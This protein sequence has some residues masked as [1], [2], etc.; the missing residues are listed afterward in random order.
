MPRTLSSPGVLHALRCF[1]WDPARCL[2]SR[3]WPL[4][5]FCTSLA[6]TMTLIF[7][8]GCLKKKRGEWVGEE[9]EE[10]TQN[11]KYC[12]PGPFPRRLEAAAVPAWALKGKASCGEKKGGNWPVSKV[13]ERPAWEEGFQSRKGRRLGF[14][15]LTWKGTNF[16]SSPC[17][18][19]VCLW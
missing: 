19:L 7:F 4:G 2:G 16:L 17:P 15:G 1:C 18:E 5:S 10:A 6:L 8:K 14:R 3:L 13:A 9:E 12:L 11:L